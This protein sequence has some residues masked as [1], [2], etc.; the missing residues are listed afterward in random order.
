MVLT[1]RPRR[2]LLLC[3]CL[4]LAAAAP[5]AQRKYVVDNSGGGDFREIQPAIDKATH[6]DLIEVRVGTPNKYKR[7]RLTKGLEIRGIKRPAVESFEVANVPAGKAAVVHELWCPSRASRT[8]ALRVSR[9]AGS[10]TLRNVTTYASVPVGVVVHDSPNV[11]F[12][13]CLLSGY[14]APPGVNGALGLDILRSSVSLRETTV[15][16]GQGGSGQKPGG[17]AIACNDASLWAVD[18]KITAGLGGQGV[19][20]G[21]PGRGIVGKPR[22]NLL[23]RCVIQAK[24][25]T[26]VDGPFRLTID[27]V[28]QG[29]SIGAVSLP[30]LTGIRTPYSVARGKTLDIT[31]LGPARSPIALFFGFDHRHIVLPATEGAVLLGGLVLPIVTVPAGTTLKIP[32]PNAKALEGLLLHVQAVGASTASRVL[33]FSGLGVVRID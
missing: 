16:G 14:L 27:C 8:P 30:H 3:A 18:C 23:M 28:V 21:P 17:D 15:T 25:S 29:L 7:F 19:F 4:A 33:N 12:E 11:H 2:R 1:K 5:S 31:T 10:V 6:G 24:G 22:K 26:A 32:I 9:C 20:R 13:R